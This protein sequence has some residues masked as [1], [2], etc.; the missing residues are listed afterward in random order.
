MQTTITGN[1]FFNGPR[2]GI[3]FNDGFGGG[4]VIS[5]N[6]LFNWC[7]ESTD[8]GPFNSWDRNMYLVHQ[9]NDEGVPSQYP[10]FNTISQ[11]MV[12]ANYQSQ[13]V[14]RSFFDRNL[15]SRMPLAFLSE[16][17]TLTS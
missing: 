11:N 2:A 17:H 10:A 4:N 7:R 8:H 13:E 5:N 15:Q 14:R 6:L 9:P 3:N 16:V 1:M 12:V